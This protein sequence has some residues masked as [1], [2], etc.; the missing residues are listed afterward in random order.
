MWTV[1]DGFA[2][3]QHAEAGGDLIDEG[4]HEIRT[5]A[6]ELGLKLSRILPGG[7]GYARP[8][9]VRQDPHRH[10]VGGARVGSAGEDA[11]RRS[12]VPIVWPS[13][14]G[15]P[16]SPPTS[17][18]AR[19]RSGSTRS[20]PTRN[21]GRRSSACAGSSWPTPTSCRCSPSSI[22]SP[23][24]IS[25]ARGRRIGST[26][27]TTVSRRRSAALLGDRVKLNTEVVAVSHRGRE[28][29]ISVKNGRDV[30]H[31][32]RNYVVFA[33]PATL[34]RRT[35]DHAGPARA[36]ARSDRPAQVRA[37]RPRP[38]SSSRSGSGAHRDGDARSDRRSP[39]APCGKANEEQR[40]RAG[41]LSLHG[42]RQRERRRRRR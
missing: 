25:R 5:L 11:R 10:A 15:T 16:R 31:M 32:T 38:C 7:F 28:V 27:A 6:E 42:W 41:I 17:P 3:G 21:C 26:A 35:P 4:Q 1:R 30:S 8:D 23:P 29:R 13:S 18:A 14:A 33:L 37:A 24:A 22:N 36:A 39:S 19:W 40:G 9:G 20:R 34:L 12:S 2:D